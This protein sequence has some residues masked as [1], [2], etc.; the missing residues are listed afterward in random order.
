MAGKKCID[1]ERKRNVIIN[2]RLSPEERTELETRIDLSGRPKQDYMIQSSLCQKIVVLGNK[3]LFEKVQQRLD[4][5]EPQL[6][7]MIESEN[8]EPEA[9]TELRIIFEIMDGWKK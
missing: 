9:M 5:I 4:K 6:H 2:F 7:K 8:I 1:Y 3:R